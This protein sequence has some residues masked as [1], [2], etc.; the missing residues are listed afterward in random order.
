[1]ILAASSNRLHGCVMVELFYTSVI[2]R[3]CASILSE[4]MIDWSFDV[5]LYWKGVFLYRWMA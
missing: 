4:G 1:M 2:F 3:A 5:Q